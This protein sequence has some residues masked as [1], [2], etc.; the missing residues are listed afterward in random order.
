ME[1]RKEIRKQRRWLYQ[2]LTVDWITQPSSNNSPPKSP[3]SE[4]PGSLRKQ[5]AGPVQSESVSVEFGFLTSSWVVT[6]CWSLDHT[7]WT[8]RLS[9]CALTFSCYQS[10]Q[11][12]VPGPREHSYSSSSCKISS[13]VSWARCSNLTVFWGF[14]RNLSNQF[15]FLKQLENVTRSQMSDRAL[16]V[17]NMI[18]FKPDFSYLWSHPFPKYT[19]FLGGRKAK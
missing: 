4:S 10:N 1:G 6:W 18:K 9:L 19:L 16:L 15:S 2:R 3:N 17:F 14:T 13:Q 11:V 5:T 8:T 7:L 12:L